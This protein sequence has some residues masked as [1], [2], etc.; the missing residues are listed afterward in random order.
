[1]KSSA[2]SQLLRTPWGLPRSL[3]LLLLLLLSAEERPG[4]RLVKGWLRLC[5]ERDLPRLPP[6]SEGVSSGLDESSSRG[7]ASRL[8]CLLQTPSDFKPG[9]SRSCTLPWVGPASLSPPWSASTLDPTTTEGP[10]L[11]SSTATPPVI[12][13]GTGS[14]GHRGWE[15]CTMGGS[16]RVKPPVEG[17]GG[18]RSGKCALL[19]VPLGVTKV[20]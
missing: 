17:G 6:Q 14:A 3:L 4:A 20:G 9:F 16:R 7:F 5:T 13:S 12:S 2:P 1:M 8:K 18:G 15:G 19:E 11:P 10:K